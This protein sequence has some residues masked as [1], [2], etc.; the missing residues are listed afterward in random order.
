MCAHFS[1]TED[2]LS[3]WGGEPAPRADRWS[4][5]CRQVHSAFLVSI[6]RLRFPFWSYPEI[7]FSSF[8]FSPSPHGAGLC[9][10][11]I[12]SRLQTF[13][14][15]GDPRS[16]AVAGSVSLRSVLLEARLLRF[17][18]PHESGTNCLKRF[19]YAWLF[20]D[21][22]QRGSMS[23]RHVAEAIGGFIR[24]ERNRFRSGGTPNAR[25]PRQRN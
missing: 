2:G 17:F 25:R 3:L 10:V 4:A 22:Q 15:F 7:F 6:A 18:N 24:M 19:V 14:S 16:I 13:A 9:F 1:H 21:P 8:S 20:V 12:H 23:P 5:L 11:C